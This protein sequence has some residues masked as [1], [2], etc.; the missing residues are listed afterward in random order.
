MAVLRHATLQRHVGMNAEPTSVGLPREDDG[1]SSRPIEPATVRTEAGAGP[2]RD[3]GRH[4]AVAAHQHRG[5]VEV[6]GKVR[7]TRPDIVPLRLGPAREAADQFLVGAEGDDVGPGRSRTHSAQL[8]QAWA[9]L[10]Q[11]SGGAHVLGA[12]REHV[13]Q[14]PLLRN[15]RSS[16]CTFAVGM[17][18]FACCWW[19]LQQLNGLLTNFLK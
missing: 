2:G 16:M 10:R 8:R 9:G 7:R 6:E 11:Q 18:S 17:A 14:R 3:H 13:E 5:I 1:R 19:R 15:G 12:G 4:V